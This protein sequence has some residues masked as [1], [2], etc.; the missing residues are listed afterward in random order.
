MRR[1]PVCS[2][3][4]YIGVC[5]GYIHSMKAWVV[6]LWDSNRRR[7]GRLDWHGRSRSNRRP[8]P[9]DLHI[10]NLNYAV[11]GLSLFAGLCVAQ[12]S[13]S[14]INI[15]SWRIPQE[16]LAC[17]ALPVFES[18]YA[19]VKLWPLG[20][21]DRH[22][23]SPAVI[24]ILHLYDS[25]RSMELRVGITQYHWVKRTTVNVTRSYTNLDGG[26]T[27]HYGP[28]ACSCRRIGTS[29]LSVFD[30]SYCSIANCHAIQDS[31]YVT[32]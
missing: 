32:L 27:L 15:Y 25:R 18:P 26:H 16:T 23:L 21:S 31:L 29:R 6:W 9:E 11:T 14:F 24:D 5:P 13:S 2:S 17:S 3:V 12:V 30:E 10:S 19:Q 1:K 4:I 20:Y 28:M 22:S 8:R 7:T